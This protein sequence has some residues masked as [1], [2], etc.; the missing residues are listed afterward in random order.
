MRHGVVPAAKTLEQGECQEKNVTRDSGA[1][2]KRKMLNRAATWLHKWSTT[3]AAIP[4]SST[5]HRLRR[6]ANFVVNHCGEVVIL[7]SVRSLIASINVYARTRITHRLARQLR[8]QCAV[9]TSRI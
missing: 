3:L 7:E 5:D 2:N 8:C 1:V 4:Q 6:A 9:T